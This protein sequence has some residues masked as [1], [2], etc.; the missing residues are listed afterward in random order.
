MNKYSAVFE[1]DMDIESG[2]LFSCHVNWA[3][4]YFRFK[5]SE[6]VNGVYIL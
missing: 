4:A 6:I 3:L 2:V 1:M 5:E